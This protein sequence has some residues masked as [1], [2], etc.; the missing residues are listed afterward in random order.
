M[1]SLQYQYL[2]TM[3]PRDEKDFVAASH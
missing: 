2:N 3:T 1:S